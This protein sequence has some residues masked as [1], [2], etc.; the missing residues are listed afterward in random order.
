MLREYEIVFCHFG[1]S[2]S[3]TFYRNRPFFSARLP[4]P[5]YSSSSFSWF[6]SFDRFTFYK[7]LNFLFCCFV[8]DFVTN[9]RGDKNRNDERMRFLGRTFENSSGK[10]ILLCLRFVNLL[11]PLSIPCFLFPLGKHIRIIHLF[12]GIIYRLRLLINGFRFDFS[13]F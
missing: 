5:S 6:C 9:S 7:Y 1:I 2:S 13:L 12:R 11:H 3:F 8:F 4:P 10:H